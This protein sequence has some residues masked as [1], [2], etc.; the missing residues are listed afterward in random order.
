MFGLVDN[1][2]FDSVTG[3]IF[4]CCNFIDIIG[5]DAH[6]QSYK[7]YIKNSYSVYLFNNYFCEKLGYIVDSINAKYVFFYKNS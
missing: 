6:F 2:V 1:V 7:I 4:L 5:F 3:Q